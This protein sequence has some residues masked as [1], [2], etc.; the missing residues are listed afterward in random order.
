MRVA[1]NFPYFVPYAGYFRLFTSTDVFVSFDCVPFPRRGF[2]HRN[3]LATHAGNA[4]WYTL[5]MQKAPRDTLIKDMRFAAGIAAHMQRQHRRFPVLQST[6]AQDHP[7]V[8]LCNAPQGE[9]VSF[10]HATLQTINQLLGLPFTVVRSSA[11]DFDKSQR[12]EA[13]VLS[14]LEALGATAYVNAPGGRHLYDAANFK[15]R[16]MTLNYL[17]PYEGSVWSIMQR[18]LT[19]QPRRIAAEINRQ[20]GVT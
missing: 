7:L 3:R 20:S 9:P 4:A 13:R 15:A 18:L 19:D 12:G 14:I 10:L 2:V 6:R 17:A 11:L 16:G 1:V 5:P 8:T